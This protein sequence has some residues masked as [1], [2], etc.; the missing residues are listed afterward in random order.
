MQLQMDPTVCRV[1]LK[2]GFVNIIICSVMWM[3]LVTI[4]CDAVSMEFGGEIVFQTIIS[5]LAK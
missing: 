4:L 1:H 3:P 2:E 5:N